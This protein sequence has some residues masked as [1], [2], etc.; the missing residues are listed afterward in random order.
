[1]PLDTTNSGVLPP[2]QPYGQ[3]GLASSLSSDYSSSITIEELAAPAGQ[4]PRSVMLC[5]P[6]LPFQ[7]AN[8][9]GTNALATKWYPGNGD[10]ATQQHLGPMEAPTN[11][12]G[13][14]NNTR[15]VRAPSYYSGGSGL[16]TVVD[17]LTLATVLE[18]ILRGG[19]RLRVTWGQ[20]SE[21]P[22]NRGKFVREGR[23]KDWDF[24][25]V[26]VQDISWT[27]GWEWQSRGTRKQT[28]TSVRDGALDASS[29]KMNLA[30]ANLASQIASA[31]FIAS[32]SN[33]YKSAT[34]IT[35]GQIESMANSPT[36]LANSLQRDV[37][38]V[39]TQLQQVAD[40][41]NTLAS[42][43][44]AVVNAAINTAKSAV[45]TANAFVD[46]MGQLPIELMSNKTT[47]HDLLR[48]YVYFETT[49]D[50]TY[51]AA[52]AALAVVRQ[53]QSRAPTPSGAGHLS[54]QD[55]QSQSGDMI[56][57]YVTKDGDT[58]ARLSVRFYGSMD[59]GVDILQANRYPWHTPFFQK[60]SI[61]WIPRLT[62]QQ[63]TS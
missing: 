47:V 13:E 55:A 18:G 59:H 62:T 26:R 15:M 35:L 48:G 46:Q 30:T 7:G 58:P 5:G 45:A 22:S 17:P 4:Q 39:Q 19:A 6:G 49:S 41:A 51:Q 1:V 43:P 34:S 32:N 40:I 24:S 42:Q 20:S 56:A 10:E 21:S 33:I 28:V 16:T 60:G 38:Q 3:G 9:G 61:L 37:L 11:W 36:V 25:V 57:V 12:K 63:K 50:L 44:T 54:P 14:W 27:V 23:A 8:W 53:M 52:L 29:A 2:P 31:P